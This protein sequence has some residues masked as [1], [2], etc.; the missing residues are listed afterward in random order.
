MDYFGKHTSIAY[1]SNEHYD[2]IPYLRENEG[3]LPPFIIAVGDARRAKAACSILPLKNAVAIHEYAEREAG[4]SARGRVDMFIGTFESS[5]TA[6][7]IL[8]LETQMGMPATEIVLR[9]VAH[10]CGTHY[11]LDGR[12]IET[13]GV[14]VIR[15]GTAGGINAANE[16]KIEISDVVNAAFS[17]GWSGAAIESLGGLQ[18]NDSSTISTFKAH[19]QELGLSFTSDGCYPTAPSDERIVK[20]VQQ[21]AAA[22][23]IPAHTGGNFSKDSLYA[24]MNDELFISMRENYQVMSTEMEHVIMAALAA[25]LRSRGI[26][27]F[28]GLVSGVIGLIPGLSFTE[29]PALHELAEK[30]ALQ[31][32]AQALCLLAK[33]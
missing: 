28:T 24:E 8:M 23:N 5:N 25:Q 13:D 32:A 27:C 1:L 29:D 21:A 31:T 17:L 33:S 11:L 15:A 22:L 9:E 16:A 26:R 20:A 30:R 14:F 3:K 19:W 7:P 12:A 6:I 18:F 2:Q 10:H 4:F